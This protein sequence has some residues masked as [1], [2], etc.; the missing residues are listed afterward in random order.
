MYVQQELLNM[1]TINSYCNYVIKQ[2]PK[3]RQQKQHLACY[4]LLGLLT[5]KTLPS[6]TPFLIANN[7]YIFC[8]SLFVLIYLVFQTNQSIIILRP[9]FLKKI[10][11]YRGNF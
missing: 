5:E 4:E 11:T 8:F 10:L 1:W 2:R 3:K 7:K 9:H 6:L